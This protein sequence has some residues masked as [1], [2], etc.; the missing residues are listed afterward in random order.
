M[1]AAD[2]EASI[3]PNRYRVLGAQPWTQAPGRT[4]I[5]LDFAASSPTN[6]ACLI[7]E[8][9]TAIKS[10]HETPPPLVIATGAASFLEYISFGKGGEFQVYGGGDLAAMKQTCVAGEARERFSLPALFRMGN[11]TNTFRSLIESFDSNQAPVRLFWV[12]DRFTLFDKIPRIVCPEF[13]NQFPCRVA[14]P[15]IA[16]PLL[17]QISKAGVTLFPIVVGDHRR[18]QV[19]A[20][21]KE[22]MRVARYIADYLGGFATAVSGAPG[23]TLLRV[24]QST[25]KGLIVSLDGP[26]SNGRSPDKQNVL[27]ITSGT[28]RELHWHR[29]FSAGREAGMKDPDM[30]AAVPLVWPAEGL[31]LEFGCSMRHDPTEPAL[32]LTIPHGVMIGA[33]GKVDVYFSYLNEQGIT[34]QRMTL[35]PRPDDPGTLCVPLIHARHGTEFQVIVSDR[36]SGW[37]GARKGLLVRPQA[38]PQ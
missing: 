12:S 16:F 27:S 10:I 19:K 2:L 26:V 24:V 11:S 29:P 23:E 14:P 13:G 36:V 38:V 37:V 25:G 33:L 3:G 35:E 6:H 15:N 30:R 22:E 18:G 4:V 5:V 8:A 21:P 17:G 34:K 20:P 7:A 9:W 28:I 1:T 32:K 31:G